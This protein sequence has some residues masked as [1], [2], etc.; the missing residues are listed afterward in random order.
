M[1]S[2]TSQPRRVWPVLAIG[3]VLAVAWGIPLA[4]SGTKFDASQIWWKAPVTGGVSVQLSDLMAV[5]PIP[6]RAFGVKCDGSD[7][8]VAIQA[9]ATNAVQC[10]LPPT[11]GGTPCNMAGNTLALPTGHSLLGHGMRAV[12]LKH[13]GAGCIVSVDNSDGW[14]IYRLS[15]DAVS[16][17]TGTEGL[18]VT[19]V[20]GPNLRGAVEDVMITSDAQISSFTITSSMIGAI[21]N[22]SVGGSGTIAVGDQITGVGVIAGT[23]V[24]SVAGP[25]TITPGQ[26]VGSESM[27][28]VHPPIPGTYG[29]FIHST[30]GN[31]LYYA[32][33]RHLVTVGWDRGVES[34]GDVG[35]GGANANFFSAY[36]GNANTTGIFFDG[37]SG[38]NSVQGHCNGSGQV[39][40]AQNCV[41]IGD[42][43][44]NSAGNFLMGVTSDTGSLGT[45]YKLPS[46]SGSNVVIAVNES[47]SLDQ[48]TADSTSF[49]LV[50][51]GVGTAARHFYAPDAIFGSTVSAVTDIFIGQSRRETG[52]A[53]KTNAD[54]TLG[55]HD[56]TVCEAS[57]SAP[58][59]FTLTANAGQAVT[60][61]D[62]DGTGITAT[63]TLTI[64]RPSGGQINGAASNLVLS[65]AGK[66]VK[67]E[68]LIAS[69]LNWSCT[70]TP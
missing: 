1:P 6:A 21:L 70:V 58:H 27:T 56:R 40:L 41:T 61:G 9:C 7:E 44:H 23:T 43:T 10:V 69:A 25:T 3:A 19:N 20:S 51:K 55:Q 65:A 35:S 13:I 18:C 36:S 22:V 2:S 46:P 57:T 49:R 59:T 24:T 62:C 14:G 60:L 38:D 31:S 28:V 8:H 54:Y 34:L 26:S 67:C 12:H 30:T 53:V 50:N 66:S 42:G 29:V 17:T 15:L 47:G 11:I 4:W 5:M 64:A 48:D 32:D 63:N 52:V 45:A 68:P 33:F 16:A 39:L 37:F